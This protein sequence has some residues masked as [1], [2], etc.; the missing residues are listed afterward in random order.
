M[1]AKA[2]KKV[3]KKASAEEGA[4]FTYFTAHSQGKSAVRLRHRP[5][6]APFSL[7][8]RAGI[9]KWGDVCGKVH[10]C[11]GAGAPVI[12][13][14]ANPN[15]EYWLHKYEMLT[16]KTSFGQG[17]QISLKTMPK[18]TKHLDV[19]LANMKK[20]KEAEKSYADA[21]G[22][23]SLSGDL[24]SSSYDADGTAAD[25]VKAKKNGTTQ[26]MHELA[27]VL[28]AKGEYDIAKTIYQ[29]LFCSTDVLPA[30]ASVGLLVEIT[31]VRELLIAAGVPSGAAQS[32][33]G[34]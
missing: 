1:A 14:F 7:V 18:L 4:A 16:T 5:G 25:L 9:H 19:V 15:R 21:D 33:T 20:D 31:F 6:A 3:A 22:L 34:Q 27:A 12:L 17:K 10:R 32:S 11:E 28:I 24:G 29:Q 8:P 30:L 23:V 26:G 2:A 13:H